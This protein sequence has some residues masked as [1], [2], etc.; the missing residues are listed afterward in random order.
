MLRTLVLS[1]VVVGLAVQSRAADGELPLFLIQRSTNA[2]AIH[3]VAKLDKQ[4]KLDLRKPVLAYWVMAATDGSR[5]PLSALEK[6]TAYGFSIRPDGSDDSYI[7]VLVS[8][9]RRE[10]HIYLRNGIAHAETMIGGCRAFLQRVFVTTRKSA[11]FNQPLFAE[12]FGVDVVTGESCY[13][14]VVRSW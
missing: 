8:D 9:R 10:I 1:A 12:L 11:I 5:Q 7:M 13:E 4:G 6:T 14:K 2:N 3:Y